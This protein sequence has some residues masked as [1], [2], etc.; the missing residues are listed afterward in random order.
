MCLVVKWL[1]VDSF[2]LIWLLVQC[3]KTFIDTLHL[4]PAWS[5]L[6]SRLT[7]TFRIC[8]V[9]WW[10]WILLCTHRGLNE[11]TILTLDCYLRMTI[12][13]SRCLQRLFNDN[14]ALMIMA[15]S[16]NIFSCNHLSSC[17]AI[18]IDHILDLSRQR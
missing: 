16:L 9:W 2:L 13:L 8:R 5:F 3:L 6:D 12:L 1:L 18:I 15:L 11:L 10:S 14:T 17:V 7:Y 4:V